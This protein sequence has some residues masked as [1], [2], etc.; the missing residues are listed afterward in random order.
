M[1]FSVES[2]SS[3]TK[4]AI[5]RFKEVKE[6]RNGRLEPSTQQAGQQSAEE[7]RPWAQPKV[8]SATRLDVVEA[9]RGS[10]SK[11]H[12][13][14]NVLMEAGG[15]NELSAQGKRTGVTAATA[16]ESDRADEAGGGTAGA[17]GNLGEREESGVS[18]RSEVE[19]FEEDLA[20]ERLTSSSWG[21]T[22]REGSNT[23]EYP[24]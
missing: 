5:F 10:A 1:G 18:G 24:D 6:V 19:T 7:S 22:S 23:I 4:S 13:Q 15:G 16:G 21:G 11:I 14:R 8:T 12:G 3:T 2:L 20:S 17:T 9:G